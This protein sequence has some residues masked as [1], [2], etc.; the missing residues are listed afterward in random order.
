MLIQFIRAPRRCAGSQARY[1]P[2]TYSTVALRWSLSSGVCSS[3]YSPLVDLDGAAPD[4]V[5]PLHDLCFQQLGDFRGRPE[6]G[7]D[8]RGAKFLLNGVQAGL[9]ALGPFHT[10]QRRHQRLRCLVHPESGAMSGNM[11][12]GTFGQAIMARSPFDPTRARQLV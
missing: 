4:Q 2:N 12:G 11:V 7:L 9:G 1:R 6:L 3:A 5:G 10:S 8:A